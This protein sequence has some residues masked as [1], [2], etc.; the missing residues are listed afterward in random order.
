MKAFWHDN[1]DSTEMPVWINYVGSIPSDKSLLWIDYKRVPA[2]SMVEYTVA[3]LQRKIQEGITF[4]KLVLTYPSEAPD[5]QDCINVAIAFG[6]DD[7][8]TV[9]AGLNSKVDARSHFSSHK[10]IRCRHFADPF[11][12]NCYHSSWEKNDKLE[13]EKREKKL[14]YLARIARPHRISMAVEL[15]ERGLTQDSVT[16][17]TGKQI[18]RAHV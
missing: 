16:I 13:P 15:L 10:K 18:G 4:D 6:C 12:L 11:F 14:A 2:V 9:D 8:A 7:I 17:V 5:W 1:F 3:V